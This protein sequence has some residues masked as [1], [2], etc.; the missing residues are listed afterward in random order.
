MESTS[1]RKL[2][3]DKS[4]QKLSVGITYAEAIRLFGETGKAGVQ[5]ISLIEEIKRELREN[6][7]H[8]TLRIEVIFDVLKEGLKHDQ[9]FMDFSGTTEYG[10]LA[11][12][13]KIGKK[14]ERGYPIWGHC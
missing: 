7:P 10:R 13:V 9:S 5:K 8:Q 4:I 11:L 14:I 6:S 12:E 3:G 2:E 1:D